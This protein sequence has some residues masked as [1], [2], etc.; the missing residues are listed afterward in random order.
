M[1][2]YEYPSHWSIIHCYLRALKK[3]KINKG[4]VEIVSAC[5]YAHYPTK[6]GY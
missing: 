1:K 4:N 6:F 2:A 5:P 3:Q